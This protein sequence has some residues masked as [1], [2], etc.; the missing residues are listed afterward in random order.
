MGTTDIMHGGDY[1][2]LCAT[3]ALCRSVDFELEKVYSVC[4]NFNRHVPILQ[5]DPW[6]SYVDKIR[7]KYSHGRVM[8]SHEE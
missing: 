3:S 4:C 7:V 2:G 1:T 6:C 5:Q 8:Y